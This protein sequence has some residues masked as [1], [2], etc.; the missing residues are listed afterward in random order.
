[1]TGVTAWTSAGHNLAVKTDTTAFTTVVSYTAGVFSGP[2]DPP[3][4]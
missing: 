1:M 4:K 3:G 2:P